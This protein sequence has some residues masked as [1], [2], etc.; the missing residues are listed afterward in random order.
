MPTII[1]G[2]DKQ[3]PTV[4]HRELYSNP[5]INHDGKECEKKDV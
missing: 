2:K 1:Y 5:V 3:G 4:E